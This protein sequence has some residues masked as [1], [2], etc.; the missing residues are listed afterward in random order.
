MSSNKP[1]SIPRLIPTPGTATNHV[2]SLLISQNDANVGGNSRENAFVVDSTV[3]NKE[4]G[5]SNRDAKVGSEVQPNRA[6]TAPTSHQYTTA[7]SLLY[8]PLLS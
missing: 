5:E 7:I 8:P 1:S 4:M 2:G 6:T 3:G